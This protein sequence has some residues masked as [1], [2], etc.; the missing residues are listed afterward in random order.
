M[1][2]LNDQLIRG[3]VQDGSRGFLDI[4]PFEEDCLQNT[5]YYF[6]LGS[7]C[8]ET[9]K[10]GQP[11]VELGP[12][13]SKLIL[14]PSGMAM[15]RSLETF[16]LSN[17]VMAIFGQ[18]SDLTNCGLEL[19]HSPFIDPTFFG[20]LELGIVNRTSSEVAIEWQQKIGKVCFFDVSDTYPVFPPLKGK[21]L[22]SKFEARRPE[23]DDDP[24]HYYKDG[25]SLR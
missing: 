10:P 22:A 7:H 15:I 9:S 14:P 16:L 1:F 12:A 3:Y 20:Q 2:L 21:A 6:R 8:K 5:S 19:M 13:R 25:R 4:E 23:R 11:L 17:K 18:V 24:P